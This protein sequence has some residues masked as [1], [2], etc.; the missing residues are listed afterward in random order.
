MLQQQFPL[1]DGN[2]AAQPRLRCQEI[3]AALIASGVVD[4][5]AYGQKFTRLIEEKIVINI[6]QSAALLCN[7]LDR[8]YPL[9]W[10][11]RRLR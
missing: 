5:I 9:G 2:K 7:L 4:I 11:V 10:L 3:V 1:G 6:R 8:L